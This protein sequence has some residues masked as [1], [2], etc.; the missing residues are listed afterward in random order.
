MRLSHLYQQAVKIGKRFDP[1][2]KKPREYADTAVLYGKP[3]TEINKVM[4][5]IDIGPAELLLAERLR[6]KRGLDLVISHHPA[7]RALANF[8]EVM[9]VQIDMLSKV[10]IEP[11]AARGFIEERKAAVERKIMPVNYNR[12][13]DVA[14]LLDIPFVCIH[15]PADNC[16]WHFLEKL[17]K[18]KKPV[19]L[20]D[21]VGILEKI[22]EYLFAKGDNNGPRIIRGSEYCP[23]GKIFLEMTGGTEG[24]EKVFDKLA[25]KGIKTLVSMHLSEGHFKTIK[26]TN[27][28]VV[29][30]GH[31]SSDTLGLNLL[32]DEIEKKHRLDITECSGF[33]RVRR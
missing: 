31:I 17:L 24:S 1:A 2:V 10:G 16:V 30:A 8:Y 18:R 5:G 19:I 28:N 22:P 33:R 6:H 29:I 4:V 9:K 32:L 15:T 3:D 12:A 20:K 21:I 26:D 14:R 27:I 23:C 7:G 25:H 13:V 11:D